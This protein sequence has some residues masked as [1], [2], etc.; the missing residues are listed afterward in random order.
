ML[1][2]VFSH[3]SAVGVN[4]IVSL[5]PADLFQQISGKISAR[6]ETTRAQKSET[7]RLEFVSNVSHI[8]ANYR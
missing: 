5:M 3:I 8:D 1:T 4:Y 6:S 7:G 2:N